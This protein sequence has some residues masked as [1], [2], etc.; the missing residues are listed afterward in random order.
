MVI[1]PTEFRKNLFKL[2]D[3]VLKTGRP[4]EIERNGQILKIVPPKRRSKLERL[5]PHPDAV[6][7]D[8]D[9]LVEMD[10]SGMW[11]PSI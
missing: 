4:L 2:L 7:G 11:K 1:T 6:N 9:D 10:W 3:E 5:E 8:S